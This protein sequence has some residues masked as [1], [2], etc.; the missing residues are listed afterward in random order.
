MARPIY[1]MFYLRL[2]E[3]WF[4]LSKEEWDQLFGKAVR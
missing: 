1:K 4:Q 3:A 2:T